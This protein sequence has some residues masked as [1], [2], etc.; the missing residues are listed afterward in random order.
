MVMNLVEMGLILQNSSDYT[1]KFLTADAEEEWDTFISSCPM[2][3]FLHTRRFLNYH[4]N[5][6]KDCSLMIYQDGQKLVG[7]FPAAID[8]KSAEII[9]HPGI[10]FGGLLH[11]GT[12][13]LANYVS[14]FQETMNIYAMN[15]CSKVTY[16]PVPYIYHSM[17]ADHDLYALWILDAKLISR[18]PSSSLSPHISRAMSSRRI[19]ALKKY[20][21]Q[22]IIET[23]SMKYTEFW[24]VLID[25]LES[26][27][28][29]SP[30]HTLD[31]IIELSE[32]FRNEIDLTVAMISDEVV[33]GIV[34][35]HSTNVVHLQYIASNPLGREFGVLDKIVSKI[36][37][38]YPGKIIDFGISSEANGKYLNSNLQTYKNE[39]G[40]GVVNYDIYEIDLGKIDI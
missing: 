5:R 29:K 15:N 17:F 31:E 4:K 1:F 19:R 13:N 40:S 34:T 2:S 23:G 25:N 10:T 6:F 18:S 20:S 30:V 36:I 12:I 32:L 3:T 8:E 14:I 26:R 11:Q 24:S 16:K 7:V 35:F 28:G 9:S 22:V 38:Q 27:Y 39:F 33:G 21:S 37:S